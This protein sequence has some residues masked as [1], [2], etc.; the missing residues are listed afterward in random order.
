MLQAPSHTSYKKNRE[1][2]HEQLKPMENVSNMAAKLNKMVLPLNTTGKKA[3]HRKYP[4][5]TKQTK[6]T[7]PP[8]TR[9]AQGA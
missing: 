2:N 9:G 1:T 7:H 3:C 8:D 6:V 5:N 4:A